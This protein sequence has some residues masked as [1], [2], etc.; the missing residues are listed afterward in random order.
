MLCP[1]SRE[2][3]PRDE[4][5]FPEA[6]VAALGRMDLAAV[7][8]PDESIVLAQVEEN[9]PGQQTLS[10]FVMESIGT[11]RVRDRQWRVSAEARMVGYAEVVCRIYLE[12]TGVLAT[13]SVEELAA[14]GVS[15]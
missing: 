9:H 6:K 5:P 13:T 11:V 15:V 12:P 14:R 8:G 1:V 7:L 10:V 4:E 3:L 2:G